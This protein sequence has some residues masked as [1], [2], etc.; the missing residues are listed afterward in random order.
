MSPRGLISLAL[1]LVCSALAACGSGTTTVTVKGAPPAT[2][3][4]TTTHSST[5]STTATT[6]PATQSTTS[7]STTTSQTHT[8]PEPAFT[9]GQAKSTPESAAA[10]VLNARGYVPVEA[11]QY[12]PQQTLTAL[13]GRRSESSEY[14]EQAFFFL[15]GRYLGT[16]TKEASASV[17]LVSQDDT[18]VTLAYPLYHPSDP[19]TAPSGGR[20]IV[21]F[22]LNDGKLQALGQIPPVHSATGLSR[23]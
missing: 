3:S 6:P 23:R 7:G 14:G 1:A 9:E 4:T 19:L 5:S 22:Q 18:E 21:H 16:D 8:A 2:T 12:H 17:Q 10:E 11:A 20:A 13:I 15:D